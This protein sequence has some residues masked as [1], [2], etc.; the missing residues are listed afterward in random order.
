ML[1]VVA[2]SRHD[3]LHAMSHAARRFT[4]PGETWEEV[5]AAQFL[6]HYPLGRIGAPADIANAALFLA[7]DEASWISG[8]D[9]PVDGGYMAKL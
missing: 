3:R 6:H 9:L 5:V 7:S 2:E 4:R 1:A 8:V